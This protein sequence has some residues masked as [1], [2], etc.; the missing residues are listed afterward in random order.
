MDILYDTL[1]D[2]TI[3]EQLFFRRK[4]ANKQ[5]PKY[6]QY[7]DLLMLQK[8]GKLK[9]IEKKIIKIFPLNKLNY[10]NHILLKKIQES[11]TLLLSE[12]EPEIKLLFDIATLKMLRKKGQEDA[13]KK[14]WKAIFNDCMN[15]KDYSVIEILLNEFTRIELFK[16]NNTNI[17]KSFEQIKTSKNIV[18]KYIALLR[19]RSFFLE[20]LFMKKRS[21]ILT[22]ED[23]IRFLAIEKILLNEKDKSQKNDEFELLVYKNFCFSIIFQFNND[24][25]N[26]QL[27]LEKCKTALF[28]NKKFIAQ[29]N[30]L[31][32]EFSS[33]YIDILILNF[34]FDGLQKFLN[35]G[36]KK[37]FLTEENKLHF[38]SIEFQ[39]WNRLYNKTCQY[40]KVELL[41]KNAS[42]KLSKWLPFVSFDNKD[43]LQGSFGI[44]YFVL[45]KFEAAYFYLANIVQDYNKKSRK[46]YH[47]FCYLFQTLIAYELK[48]D[49]LFDSQYNNTYSHFNRHKIGFT[50]EKKILNALHKTYFERNYKNIKLI[51]EDVLNYIN[52]EK[53]KSEQTIIFN[54]FNFPLW[55]ESKILRKKYKEYRI[56]RYNA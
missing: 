28:I 36:I 33:F 40:D 1:N 29:H 34:N 9:L 25:Q 5:L 14:L 46:E 42:K 11:N 12:T 45:E 30:D 37:Y 8:V 16:K 51:F 38:E 18:K 22:S 49:K 54:F 48:N 13:A 39:A 3:N 31:L 24:Y 23:K 32:F 26:A 35:S 19:Y 43:L 21:I 6:V 53:N 15:R 52:D 7:F 56:E 50:F 44:A 10:Y 4:Y 17:L 55:L 20:L 47:T 2:L 27:F 41:L